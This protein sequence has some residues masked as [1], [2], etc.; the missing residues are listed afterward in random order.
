MERKYIAIVFVIC[1]IAG[2]ASA[3]YL[4]QIMYPPVIFA[5]IKTEEFEINNV[6]FPSSSSAVISVTYM[7]PNASIT[8]SNVTIDDIARTP[9]YGGSIGTDGTL[10]K[11][12]SG[13]ITIS[14]WTWTAGHE[15]TFA[16]TAGRWKLMY[17]VTTPAP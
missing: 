12:A 6:T 8:I 17:P 5:P 9:T 10:A 1:L 3:I 7:G 15:Y 16:L 14:N 4:Y 13:N 2:L 11:G